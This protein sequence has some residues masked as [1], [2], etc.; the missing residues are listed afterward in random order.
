ML[1]FIIFFSFLF[2]VL[3]Y[4]LHE[5]AIAKIILL[6]RLLLTILDFSALPLEQYI[7]FFLYECYI[8]NVRFHVLCCGFSSTCCVKK[9]KQ[10]LA[11]RFMLSAVFSKFVLSAI[12]K[13]L[14]NAVKQTSVPALK[15]MVVK[16]T[17]FT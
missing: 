7:F 17:P 6:G 12:F 9:N 5:S 3:F 8:I 13:T 11:C 4:I 14:L 16:H 10:S 2:Y 15:W 1:Q